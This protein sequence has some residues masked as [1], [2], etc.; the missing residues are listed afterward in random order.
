MNKYLE[1]SRICYIF[2][3]IFLPF[4]L[5]PFSFTPYTLSKTFFVITFV[6]L[7]LS[8]FFLSK[9]KK[10]FFPSFIFLVLIL[11]E[12]ISNFFNFNLFIF[13]RYSEHLYVSITVFFLVFLGLNLYERLNIEKILIY[14]SFLVIIPSIL[15]LFFNDI[16][17]S[18]TLGQANFFGIYLTITL[19]AI[20]KNFEDLKKNFS[21]NLLIFYIGLITFFLFK[22]ASLSSFVSL[23]IGLCF[24]RSSL[25]L[26]N[27]KILIVV[28]IFAL[29][30]STIFGGVFISKFQDIYNQINRPK[31]TLISDSFLIRQILWQE[32]FKIIM[33]NP[34][35]VFFGFGPNNFSYYFEKIRQDKLQDYS[36]KYLLYDKPHNYF[37]EILFSYG[38]V[39]LLLFLYIFY[40][41]FRS[42]KQVGYLLIPLLF[43]LFFNWTDIYLKVFIF[44][45]IFLSLKK[46]EVPSL[47]LFNNSSLAFMLIIFT[48]FAVLFYRDTSFYF[49]DTSYIFSYSKESILNLKV[50]D[51]VVLVESLKFLNKEERRE[52]FDYLIKNFP[53]NQAILFHFNVLF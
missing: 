32:T 9:P 42:D 19:L 40:Q 27:K 31:Q 30:S 14:S 11:I 48:N 13:P 35:N 5:S 37:L 47:N 38:L 29:F 39:Y 53:N 45:I 46:E 1:I 17:A 15:D 2:G 24:L 26:L 41:A 7:S 8:F 52:I 25:R 51:P 3:L 20:L 33:S 21:K 43:F 16:R 34:Q 44:L 28:T 6:F 22:A 36:E 12:F 4:V 49:K 18:G 23:V 50:E 10:Y